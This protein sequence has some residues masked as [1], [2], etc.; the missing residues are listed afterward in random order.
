LLGSAENVAIVEGHLPHPRQ[1]RRWP[2]KSIAG[3]P[4]VVVTVAQFNSTLLE[5]PRSRPPRG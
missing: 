2:G 1:M 3:R 5:L 4:G